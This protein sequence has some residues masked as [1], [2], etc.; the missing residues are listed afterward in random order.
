MHI[1]ATT[2]SRKPVLIL[3][4]GFGTTLEDV[5]HQDISMPLWSARPIEDNPELIIA[6]HL[7][8][9]RAGADVILTSTYQCAFQTFE[10]SGYTREDGVRIL[11]KA[12]LLATEARRQ[13]KEEGAPDDTSTGFSGTA[14]VRDIKIAL[15]LGPFGATLSPAQEF[16]GFYPPPYGPKGLS[17]EGGNYNAFPDSDDGKAQEEKAVAALTA[18]HLER[19][20]ALVGDVETWAAIDF[21]AFETVPLVREIRAIRHAL[22]LLV[23]EHGASAAKPWWISTV[24]PGGRF[25]QERSPGGGRLTVR[26][27]VEAVMG[28]DGPGAPQ[29]PTPWGLGVNCT[30]PQFIGGLLK[31]MTNIL[32]ELGNT[33]GRSQ[34]PWLVVY[35]NRGDVYDAASQTWSKGTESIRQKWAVHVWADVQKVAGS[36]AWSGCLIGGCCKTGPQEIAELLRVSRSVVQ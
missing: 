28:E 18:F 8:F 22:E 26:E 34:S 32:E 23:Q 33:A 11:R 30:E 6:A 12:V 5:F 20:R 29:S 3:D 7:A 10:R 19:L 1:H 36:K 9:L 27:V 13:Y 14:H 16:D 4:G 35:P 15:S 21:V 24:Y 17:Q 31:E 2:P 25:P